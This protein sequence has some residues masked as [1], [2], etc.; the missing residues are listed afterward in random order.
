M[1]EII[2]YK[3]YPDDYCI[4]SGR[5]FRTIELEPCPFCGG[6]AFLNAE[7]LGAYGECSK[8]GA[9]GSPHSY[10][11]REAIKLWNMRFDENN[12]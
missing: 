8:C 11:E 6:R 10:D 7:R 3:D 1:S 9:R 2:N 12:I 5:E 4:W